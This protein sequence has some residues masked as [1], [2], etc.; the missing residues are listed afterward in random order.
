[1]RRAAAEVLAWLIEQSSRRRLSDV[2]LKV[3]RHPVTLPDKREA[4]PV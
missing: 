3:E 4:F 1:M 2:D